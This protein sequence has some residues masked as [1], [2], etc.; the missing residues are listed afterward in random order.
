VRDGIGN[1][2]RWSQ[3]T[4]SSRGSTTHARSNSFSRRLSFGGAAGFSFGNAQTSSPGRSGT[5]EPTAD[6]VSPRATTGKRPSRDP[7]HP[8]TSLPPIVPLP[9][10]QPIDYNR[11]SPFTSTESHPPSAVHPTTAVRTAAPDYL[12][13]YWE[14][15]GEQEARDR[16]LFLQSRI[17]T[18][19]PHASSSSSTAQPVGGSPSRRQRP[20][21]ERSSSRGHSRH[22]SQA[23]KTSSGTTSSDRS[24][25]RAGRPPSQ[26]AMLSVA[27][28]KANTAVLLDN[29]QNVEGA[30]QAY[31]EACSLLQQ[32]MLRSTADEDKR[33]LEAIVSR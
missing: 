5:G 33:K 7:F 18:D 26:K 9:A 30:M 6:A 8:A 4:T 10:L 31:S 25:E 21:R 2:N 19:K 14:R 29:A 20:D 27:L 24:R 12:G 32:V 28:Q 22:H 15:S 16:H 3:S 17:V 23:G 11:A 13:G 1:L